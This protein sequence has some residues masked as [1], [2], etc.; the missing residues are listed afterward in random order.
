MDTIL[1]DD[2][3]IKLKFN[4]PT[5]YI[6]HKIIRQMKAGAANTATGLANYI[7]TKCRNP[8]LILMFQ[9]PDTLFSLPIIKDEMLI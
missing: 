9:L 8:V 2:D 5:G 6:Q 1:T 4:S 7:I 3:I